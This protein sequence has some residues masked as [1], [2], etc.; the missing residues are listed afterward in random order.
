MEYQLKADILA[1][2]RA[3]A[4]ENGGHSGDRTHPG[5]AENPVSPNGSPTTVQDESVVTSTSQSDDRFSESPPPMEPLRYRDSTPPTAQTPTYPCGGTPRTS[6]WDPS[7]PPRKHPLKPKQF[8]PSKQP[9]VL[10]VFLG[11]DVIH[12]PELEEEDYNARITNRS[13]GANKRDVCA[14]SPLDSPVF[15]P[16]SKSHCYDGWFLE[17]VG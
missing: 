3:L 10:R 12:V 8:S 4:Q 17:Q 2:S 11:L 15:S 16:P 6:P 13:P 1:A 9:D 7:S 14:S 5:E